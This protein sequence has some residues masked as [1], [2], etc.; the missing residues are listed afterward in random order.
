LAT[1]LLAGGVAFTTLV[2]A[3]VGGFLLVNRNQQMQAAAL[4]NA[5]NRAGVAAQLLLR[6]TEPQALYAATS[7]AELPLTES[8]LVQQRPEALTGESSAGRSAATVPGINAAVIS[9]QGT[10]LYTTECQ[11]A[12]KPAASASRCR[13]MTPEHVLAGAPVVMKTLA[14]LQREDCR[15][16]AAGMAAAT[17]ACPT[18][19][20]GIETLASGAPSFDVAVPVRNTL[21]S[22]EAPLGVVVCTAPLQAQMQRFSPVIGFPAVFLA[23]GQH[24]SLLRYGGNGSVPSVSSVPAALASDL[25]A[26]SPSASTPAHAMYS[27]TTAGEVAGSFVPMSAPDGTTAGYIGV[28]VPLALFATGTAQEERTI[29]ELAITAMVLLALLVLLFVDRF[30]RK[31]V[32]TLEH[33]VS[34]I[35]AGDY[36]SDVPVTSNDELGRL[37]RSVNRMREQIAGYVHHIDA[38][39][40]RLQTVSRALTTTTGGIDSL[41]DAVLSAAVATAGSNAT[42]MLLARRGDDL[43]VTRIRGEVPERGLTS[44]TI[45]SILSGHAAR[46]DREGRHMLVVPMLYQ[47]TVT[48]ALVTV[49]QRAVF[50]SDQRALEILANN[51]AVA[52]VNTRMFEQ[53]KE[54][55][56]R[57]RELNRMK[58]DFLSAAQ[59]ELRTPVLAIQAQIELLTR[60][61]AKWDDNAKMD[62]LRDIEISTGLLGEQLETVVDFS[63]ASSDSIELHPVAVAVATAVD[64]AL[65]DVRRHFKHGI[66]VEVRTEIPADCVVTA[67][68]VKFRKVLRALIDNAIKFARDQ[69]TVMLHANAE[70]ATGLCRIEISD[71]GVGISEEALPRVFDRFFQ[72]DNSRTRKYAGMGLGLALA[73]KLCEAHGATISVHSEPG[74]GTCVTM[75]WPLSLDPPRMHAWRSEKRSS[76]RPESNGGTGSNSTLQ[77]RAKSG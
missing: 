15:L 72:E 30:V 40:E 6:V 10:V 44:D 34:R 33:G 46:R 66:P 65:N 31:P 8:S 4:S 57:L 26:H 63:L 25:H 14:T 18:H 62:L 70:H 11:S 73:H 21:D 29:G 37:A 43:V 53:E 36:S 2:I 3:A 54:T 61:W 23:A 48:G 17:A 50:E 39:I 19:V 28:E 41:Q 20:D 75:L 45:A 59:H 64:D 58:S 52:L 76:S 60:A 5:D 71:D 24:E 49:T 38:S 47:G 16:Q 51:S 7:L 32:A 13:T 74:T 1:R 42:A 67:D 69:G 9:T 35:A 12:G 77:R 55:V 22:S 56:H 68:G 27:A